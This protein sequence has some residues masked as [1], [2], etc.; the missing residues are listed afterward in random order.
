M[1]NFCH[2][3]CFIN[4]VVQIRL[5]LLCRALELHNSK[6]YLFQNTGYYNQKI[7]P[8]LKNQIIAAIQQ[9]IINYVSR[10]YVLFFMEKSMF[11]VYVADQLRIC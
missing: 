11:L 8:N 6:C 10:I 5:D 2:I 7:L 3:V 9:S 1:Q 4:C